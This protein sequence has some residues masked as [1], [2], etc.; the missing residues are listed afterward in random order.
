MNPKTCKS[1]V[2][3]M[4][5]LLYVIVAIIYLLEFI[6]GVLQIVSS[7][8]PFYGML[9]SRLFRVATSVSLI[10]I[11]INL[12]AKKK[13]HLMTVGFIIMTLCSVMNWIYGGL[14]YVYMFDLLAVAF[15]VVIVALSIKNPPYKFAQAAWFIPGT[16]LAFGFILAVY[17]EIISIMLNYSYSG[18]T[19]RIVVREVFAF[20]IPRISLVVANFLCMKW[21]SSP[22]PIPGRMPI[23]QSHPWMQSAPQQPWQQ[24][25]QGEQWQQP[26]Q[27]QQW[28]QTMQSQ[29][30]WQQ[31]VQ[32]QMQWQATQ[33]QPVQ[34]QW[35]SQ[36][37]LK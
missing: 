2:A 16:F 34:Q 32:S 33:E 20:F 21:I 22:V 8:Y 36:Q 37:P 27:A 13:T 30:P 5:A 4:A 7:G 18:L 23:Y 9:P 3:I 10:L 14:M 26:T 12:F 15:S 29:Q 11:S 31:P 1:G 25:T 19:A 35:W 6:I 17:F 24:P 28:Q